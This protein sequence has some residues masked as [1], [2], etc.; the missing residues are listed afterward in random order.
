MLNWFSHCQSFASCHDLLPQ[1]LQGSNFTPFTGSGTRLGVTPS[2]DMLRQSSWT[3]DSALSIAWLSSTAVTA[4][5]VTVSWCAMTCHD[6]PWCVCENLLCDTSMLTWV[7]RRL[8]RSSICNAEK[9]RL[10]PALTLEV[11]AWKMCFLWSRQM[12]CTTNPRNKSAYVRPHVATVSKVPELGWDHSWPWLSISPLNLGSNSKYALM[13][14]CTARVYCFRQVEKMR[15]HVETMQMA[16]QS[17]GLGTPWTA[18]N[19]WTVPTSDTKSP[20]LTTRT[21]PDLLSSF[22]RC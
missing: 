9:G 10:Q 20:E 21:V 12:I 2:C 14:L 5:A 11:F 3:V 6:M 22:N 16:L 13:T 18:S 19:L 4:V 17:E 1:A 7:A 8:T 15:K